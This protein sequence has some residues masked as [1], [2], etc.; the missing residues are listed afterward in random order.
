MSEKLKLALEQLFGIASLFIGIVLITKAYNLGAI[1]IS[2]I[3]GLSIGTIVEIDNHLNSI[4][5]R[6]NKKLLLKDNSVELDQ[7][8]T[9]IVLFSFSSSGIL[10]AMT[11]AVSNDS[12]ILLYKAILDLFTAIVFSSKL[13]LRVSLIAIPQI[14]VQMLSFSFGKL[15]FSLLQ[16]E[17]YGDFSATGGVIQLMVGMNILK[18]CRTKPLNCIL[19]LVLIIPISS[20]W[21]ILF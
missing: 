1:V 3:I 17:V 16:G 14:V 12:S 15:L 20:L 21:Q 9:L 4:I 18:I 19:A 13:G 11:E 5:F 10:G 6:I 8:S 2:L 7:F